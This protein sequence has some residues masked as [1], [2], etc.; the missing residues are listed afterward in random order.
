LKI[1]DIQPL[2][3]T[4]VWI[5]LHKVLAQ[6][7]N[8]SLNPKCFKVVK[9]NVH[10]SESNAFSKSTDY[11]PLVLDNYRPISLL[12]ID[13]KLLSHV[14]AQRLKKVWEKIVNNDQIGYIRNRFNGFNHRQIQDL[15]D[16]AESYNVEGAIVC[17]FR[18]KRLTH[19]NVHLSWQL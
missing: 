5:L 19:L 8:D 16:F 12:N 18:K 15:I 2:F 6:I 14:L 4:Q 3:I 11:C 1:S 13:L 7:I 17:W 10:S 9:I